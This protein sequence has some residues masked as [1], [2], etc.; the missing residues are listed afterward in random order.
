MLTKKLATTLRAGAVAA[1]S[2]GA[3]AQNHPRGAEVNGRLANQNRRIDRDD[4]AG[5]I[6]AQQAKP[7]RY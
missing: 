3:W 6:T 2:A 5:K 7:D 1:A 4:A